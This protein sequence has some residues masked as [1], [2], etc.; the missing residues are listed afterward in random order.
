M[1]PHAPPLPV[2][3]PWCVFLLGSSIGLLNC[4]TDLESVPLS[5]DLENVVEFKGDSEGLQSFGVDTAE[6]KTDNMI[7]RKDTRGQFTNLTL[8][9]VR[10][11][12]NGRRYGDR[13]HVE[14]GVGLTLFHCYGWC[15]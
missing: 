9:Y 12:I 4:S 1:L 13:I 8:I 6:N 7:R 2:N 14:P 11:R 5:I 10:R 15:T 3:L